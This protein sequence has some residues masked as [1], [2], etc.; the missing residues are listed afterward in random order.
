MSTL[1]GLSLSSIFWFLTL[2]NILTLYRQLE[3]ANKERV[4]PYILPLDVRKNFIII[5]PLRTLLSSNFFSYIYILVS[6]SFFLKLVEFKSYN[7]KKDR[8]P[9]AVNNRSAVYIHTHTRMCLFY[10]CMYK[11]H[12]CNLNVVSVCVCMHGGEPYSPQTKI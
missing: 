9:T 5:L 8:I 10:M 11:L 2:Y 7:R 6:L 12:T 4:G 3:D 1:W